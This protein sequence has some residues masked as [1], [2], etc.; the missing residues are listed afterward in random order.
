M[1]LLKDHDVG[2]PGAEHRLYPCSL[3]GHFIRIAVRLPIRPHI[4]GEHGDL[5]SSRPGLHRDQPD[6]WQ[7][8]DAGHDQ[9]EGQRQP[10]EEGAAQA[11]QGHEQEQGQEEIG[12]NDLAEGEQSTPLW[13]EVM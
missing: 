13:S 12:G 2:W 10:Q 7:E 6:W 4:P 8:A 5:P 9:A 1:R 3:T 11:G